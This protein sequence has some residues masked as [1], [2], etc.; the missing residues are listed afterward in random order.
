MRRHNLLICALLLAGTAHGLPEDRS[1]PIE[2]EADSAEYA[3][4]PAPSFAAPCG[5]P[6]YTG[7]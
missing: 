5:P 1:K 7:R 4:T 6:L 3:K 2:L